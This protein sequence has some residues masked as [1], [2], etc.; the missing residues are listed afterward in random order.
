MARKILKKRRNQ[1]EAKIASKWKDC[2]YPN[3]RLDKE[4][5]VQHHRDIWMKTIQ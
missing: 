1:T 4:E 3:N 2:Y 5:E